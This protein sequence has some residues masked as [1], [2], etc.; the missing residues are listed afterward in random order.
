MKL[1]L[2]T[3][4]T[5]EVSSAESR[6]H[7]DASAEGGVLVSRL[8]VARYVRTKTTAS[9]VH[10]FLFRSFASLEEAATVSKSCHA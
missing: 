4:L 8:T 10:S 5:D 3:F 2:S 6:Q 9:A 7:G 1:F